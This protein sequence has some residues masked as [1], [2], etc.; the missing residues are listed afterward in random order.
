MT[1]D[2][3]NARLSKVLA[4]PLPLAV[5]RLPSALEGLRVS[6]DRFCLLAGVEA[7]GG[8]SR[9]QFCSQH[10]RTALWL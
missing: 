3:P 9:E 7:L 4:A 1:K 6:V 2:I 8:R 10:L 5:P